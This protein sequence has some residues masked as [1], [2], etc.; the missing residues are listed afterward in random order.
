MQLIAYLL[1]ILEELLTYFFTLAYKVV[2]N[3]DLQQL[4]S[5]GIW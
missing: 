2:F 4:E 5:E 3:E 1:H